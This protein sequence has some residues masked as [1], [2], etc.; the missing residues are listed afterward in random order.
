MT[1]GWQLS[2]L[3]LELPWPYLCNI[4]FNYMLSFYARLFGQHSPSAYSVVG[5]IATD[6]P[7][8]ERRFIEQLK[9]PTKHLYEKVLHN[10]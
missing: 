3:K 5:R 10:S 6:I 9:I 7:Y 1:G 8:R 2:K 4:H